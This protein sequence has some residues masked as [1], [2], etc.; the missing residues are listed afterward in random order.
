MNLY[1]QRVSAS[2]FPKSIEKYNIKKALEEW[3]HTDQMI[4]METPDK[5]CELCGQQHLRYQFEIANKLNQNSLWIGSECII[6]FHITVQDQYGV[7]LSQDDANK[8]IK[9]NK[10]K[11]I[12]DAKV[13]SVIYSL[14]ALASV[15]DEFKIESFEKYY[16]ENKKFT[17]KQAA[18]LVWRFKRYKIAYIPSHFKITMRGRYK[19]D[20]LNLEDWQLK[21]VRPLLSAAQIN[22]LYS[23]RD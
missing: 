19:Q 11:L 2:I 17:P 8:K 10:A 7:T 13:K 21:N 18:I 15:D 23:I 20:L 6:R 22:S 9:T 3:Y 4:D 14:I 16:K 1:M 12:A 5:V